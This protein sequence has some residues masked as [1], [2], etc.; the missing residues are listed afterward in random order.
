MLISN[1]LSWQRR[2]FPVELKHAINMGVRGDIM[3]GTQGAE[4]V[5]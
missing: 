2:W 1:T 5:E 4:E 3:V